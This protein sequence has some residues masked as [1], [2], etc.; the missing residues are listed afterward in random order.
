VSDLRDL[1]LDYVPPP[2]Q[3][4]GPPVW[5]ILAAGGLVLVLVGLAVFGWYSRR[6]RS[7]PQQTTAPAATGERANRATRPPLGGTG[8]AIELPPLNESDEL[9]RLLVG[10]LSSHPAVVAWLATDGLIRNA[11]VVVQNVAAGETPAGHLRRIGPR[12]GFA[13]RPQ[14]GD[15]VMDPRSFERYT[16]IADAVA[17][18]DTAGSARLYG[19]LKPR[20]EE[21]YAELGSPD[22]RFDAVLERAIVLLLETPVVERDVR[23]LSRGALYAYADPRLE[24]LSPAQKQLV[25]T[26]PRNTRLIQTKLRDIALALG[27]TA[28]RLPEP[29][30]IQAR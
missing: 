6:A 1:E 14:A 12:A 22:T 20:V 3:P 21:A 2:Q 13:V 28:D 29:T 17:S 4:P 26:G 16:S 11:T 9:V 7:G 10:H 8:D 23:L 25:R 15:T 24:R 18:L 27:I 30:T 5:P 19:T